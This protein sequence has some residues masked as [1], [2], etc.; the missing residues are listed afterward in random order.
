MKTNAHHYEA[1][2]E[3]Y[4]RGRGWPFV[5][6]DES[7]RTVFADAT[8]K[9]FDLLIYGDAGRHL[10]VDLKGRKFPAGRRGG[11]RWENWVTRE[12]LRSLM[13]WERAFGAG[14]SAVLVF[15]YWLQGPPER[16]PFDDVHFHRGW[17]Y[18]FTGIA[19]A[20][21]ADASRP[22]SG[23][24]GTCSMPGADFAGTVRDVSAFL[25]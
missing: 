17:F 6:V 13:A 5:G 23:R 2:F 12:D 11:R 25:E 3:S 4:L 8:L 20:A 24:W 16:S 19:V 10:I 7:R 21:Y 18:A 14:F 22:R 15:A 9:S 1:A